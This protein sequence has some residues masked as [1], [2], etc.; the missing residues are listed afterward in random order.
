M[1]TTAI[2]EVGDIAFGRRFMA[3]AGVLGIITPESIV[4]V[5]AT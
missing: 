1:L 5:P 3:I 2:E 4:V